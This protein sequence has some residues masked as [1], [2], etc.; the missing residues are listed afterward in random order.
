MQALKSN[1]SA[2]LGSQ[3]DLRP[4]RPLN[5][6]KDDNLV[7]IQRRGKRMLMGL[8]NAIHKERYFCSFRLEKKR[9]KGISLLVCKTDNYRKN[10][11]QFFKSNKEGQEEIST[12]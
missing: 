3:M 6:K 7:K 11:D 8:E 1:Y 12:I 5:F 2:L 10:D 9:L 4:V